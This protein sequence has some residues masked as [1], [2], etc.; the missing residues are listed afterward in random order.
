MEIVRIEEVSKHS[1]STCFDVLGISKLGATEQ[2]IKTRSKALF[3]HVHPD[4]IHDD[5]LKR[6]AHNVFQL[7]NQSVEEA[8]KLVN[9]T[10]RMDLPKPV[11]GI[12]YTVERSGTVV[13]LRWRPD[14][15]A[16]FFRVFAAPIQQSYSR[17]IDQGT[18]AN[19]TTDSGELEYAI[20]AQSRAG[21]D[22]LFQKGRFEVKIV[23]GNNAGESSPMTITVDLTA[24]SVHV[25]GLK[26][27]HTI[28]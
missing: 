18:V 21:N 19:L 2:S 13:V 10:S 22:Q 25:P 7:I 4:K 11:V 6:R 9:T 23:A 24:A 14:G 3:R 17:N 5:D 12:K 27:H 8:V 16:Q 26:R 1:S 28:C 20:S 15:S